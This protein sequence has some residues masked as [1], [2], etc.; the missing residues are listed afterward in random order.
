MHRRLIVLF[1]FF[2]LA[3]FVACTAQESPPPDIP[4]EPTATPVPGTPPTPTPI[5]VPVSATIIE[6]YTVRYG[7]TLGAIAARYDLSI[8]D[9]MR[10]NGLTN[11]N[12]LQIGQ[13][14]KIPVQVTRAA[15]GDFGSYFQR[16]GAPGCV[17]SSA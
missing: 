1:P 7:D 4:D 9:L 6:T 14:L 10:L 2:A 8:E 15:P 11:P 12:A 5:P 3:V 16:I 17:R 13:V